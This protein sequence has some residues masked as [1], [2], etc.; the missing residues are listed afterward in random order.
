MRRRHHAER[1]FLAESM[2]APSALVILEPSGW[3]AVTI[4]YKGSL[5]LRAS[6]DQPH[7][8]GAGGEP[9]APDRCVALIRALQEPRRCSP[10]ATPVSSNRWTSACSDSRQRAMGS[11]ITA[12]VDDRCAH[13]TRLRCGCAAR[14]AR[15]SVPAA[16]AD[17]PRARTG[18]AHQPGSP[19]ARRLRSSD[20]CDRRRTTI[21]AQ[22]RDVR[23]QHPRA[24]LGLPGD[25]VRTWRFATRPHAART[26]LDR[27]AGARGVGARTSRW[28]P[29]DPRSRR[30]R[31]RV[32]RRRGAPSARRPS[33]DR[34]RAGHLRAPRR[35]AGGF[36]APPLRGRTDLRFSS[37]DVL[38]E[39][40]VVFA[41][42]HHGE[43]SAGD[44]SA[45]RGG[46]GRDRPRRRFPPPGRG[47]LSALVRVDP[48][49]AAAPRRVRCTASPRCTAQRSHQRH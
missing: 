39:A 31:R 18:G 19:L 40:D 43:S 25:R 45:S 27:G 49:G 21:Q 35:Q 4:G 41:C 9:S 47:G 29:D 15:S 44:R 33:G 23:P 12:S 36:R 3:D 1:D 34:G 17:R 8:H 6:V 48:P 38:G 14:H 32:C 22:D 5:R 10:M 20:P 16:D 13:P 42:M 30:R 2:A 26:H 24:G 46:A 11:W 37:R 28:A 7:A